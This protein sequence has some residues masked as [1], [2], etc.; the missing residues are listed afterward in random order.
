MGERVL[1]IGAGECGL[2]ACWLIQK[3]KLASAFSVAG[4][5]DDDPHKEG[6][7]IDGQRVFGLTRRIPELVEQLDIGLILF[8]IENIP[9]E[10]EQ[11]HPEPVPPDARPPDRDSRPAE[12]GAQPSRAGRAARSEELAP[13][14]AVRGKAA[15]GPGLGSN[16]WPDTGTRRGASQGRGL[17]SK[18]HVI[19]NKQ[20]KIRAAARPFGCKAPL[21]VTLSRP[22]RIR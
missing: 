20:R 18:A 8:A 7:L 1:V 21:R 6:M 2:L 19:L 4:M 14:C 9:A 13:G 5:V 22:T 17:S 10:D 16:S 11:T 15:G 12:A 3:S